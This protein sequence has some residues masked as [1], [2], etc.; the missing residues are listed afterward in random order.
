FVVRFAVSATLF[1]V[2]VWFAVWFAVWFVVLVRCFG[3]GYLR[4][5]SSEPDLSL[6]T[7]GS[8][9]EISDDGLG[10]RSRHGGER[11]GERRYAGARGE[12]AVHDDARR[13]I[14]SSM[15]HRVLPGREDARHGKARRAL[16]RHAGRHEDQGRERAGRP[17][18]QS[19]RNAGR[20]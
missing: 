11:T 7:H 20:L 15:A 5:L 1:R 17:P 10:S 19:G 3:L 16:A 6:P 14:Q 12:S 2:V 4:C 8:S 9:D 13:A 18:V